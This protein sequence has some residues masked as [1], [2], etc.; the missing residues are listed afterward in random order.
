MV[1]SAKCC[2]GGCL[3]GCMTQELLITEEVDLEGCDSRRRDKHQAKEKFNCE[4]I[5]LLT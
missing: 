3:E 5:H 2:G 4:E 1:R